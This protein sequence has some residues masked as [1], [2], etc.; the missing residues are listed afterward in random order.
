MRFPRILQ[1]L[2][3]KMANDTLDNLL[4]ECAVDLFYGCDQAVEHVFGGD[5]AM[6]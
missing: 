5:D 3:E 2:I 6:L 4:H 1:E